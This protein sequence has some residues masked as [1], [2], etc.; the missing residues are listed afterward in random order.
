[1]APIDVEWESRALMLLLDTHVLDLTSPSNRSTF[2]AHCIATGRSA[3][4]R[5]LPDERLASSDAHILKYSEA[6]HVSAVAI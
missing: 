4:H 1:M 3:D 6:G 5:H 2:R